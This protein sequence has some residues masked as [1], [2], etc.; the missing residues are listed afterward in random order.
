MSNRIQENI[1][2]DYKRVQIF[3][4]VWFVFV[5]IVTLATMC[6]IAYV[7]LKVLSH[8]GII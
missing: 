7:I 1:N 3:A 4:I 8:F 5:A 6:G 2:R